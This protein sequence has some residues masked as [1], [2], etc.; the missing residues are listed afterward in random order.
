MKIPIFIP[1]SINVWL[2]VFKIQNDSIF[3][4]FPTAVWDQTYFRKSSA[5]I[6]SSTI[7]KNLFSKNIEKGFCGKF[8]NIDPQLK[9]PLY[10][11][12]IGRKLRKNPLTVLFQYNSFVKYR[13]STYFIE[14][15]E[16]QNEISINEKFDLAWMNYICFTTFLWFDL[17]EN[18]YMYFL[19]VWRHIEELNKK[20]M[21]YVSY[22]FP[23][24]GSTKDR[25]NY[26]KQ[27]MY[28]AKL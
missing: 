5:T 19:G 10:N 16:K 21:I 24:L 25:W 4:N 12:S 20:K 6:T 14:N 26:I 22:R 18:T 9:L 1:F 27:E 11:T 13:K 3:G 23:Y 28:R 8:N 2:Y 17:L 7:T 15:G